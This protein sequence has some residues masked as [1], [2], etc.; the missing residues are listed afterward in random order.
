MAL[1]LNEDEVRQVATMAMALDAVDE[2]FGGLGRGEVQ[3]LPRQRVRLPGGNLH[4]LI[5]S[6][7]SSRALGL[8][9]YASYPDGIRFLV[10]VF[11]SEDGDLLAIMEADRLGQLRTGAASGIATRYL[12]REDAG[13]VGQI[14]AGW[15]SRTQIEAVCA[16]RPI[17]QVRVYSRRPEP[18]EAYCRAMSAQLGVE[19]VPVASGREAV[20]GADVLI[21]LTT[22][23]EPVLLGDWLEP[24]QHVNAAG[25]N[26]ADKQE[27]DDEAIRRADV[28]TAD[29]VEQAKI[30]SGD[31][32]AS[33]DHGRIAWEQVLGLGDVVAGKRPGRT[34][35]EQI[36]LFESQGLGV[37]DLA[38]AARVYRAARERGLGVE[39]DLV[40]RRRTD[41]PR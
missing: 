26:Y 7:P 32:I 24:G 21:V 41:V 18:R 27:L 22:A 8:K 34:S 39:I 40:G 33:V 16:V 11:D 9:T 29:S 6:V 38:L 25:S 2:V 23:R 13:I 15:H 30:E 37:Q 14:G 35:P 3:A 19:F 31:L 20:R 1:F 36:T 4:T 28:I 12:A 17:R 10:L 5:G